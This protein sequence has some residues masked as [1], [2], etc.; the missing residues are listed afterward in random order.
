MKKFTVT[1]VYVD[2]R[3]DWFQ[4]TQLEE[5]RARFEQW[6]DDLYSVYVSIS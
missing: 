6:R 1:V 4:S 3:R 5:A 2:G